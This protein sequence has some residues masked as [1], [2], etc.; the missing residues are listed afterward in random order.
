MKSPLIYTFMDF[1][2]APTCPRTSTS[3][4]DIGPRQ[5]RERSDFGGLNNYIGPHKVGLR[6][7]LVTSKNIRYE[8]KP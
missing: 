5:Q 2:F 8:R 7:I 1:V 4:I 6:I 3:G